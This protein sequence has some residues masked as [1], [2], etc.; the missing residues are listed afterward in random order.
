MLL[1]TKKF[2]TP[3]Q[4]DRDRAR[5]KLIARYTIDQCFDN[6]EQLGLLGHLVRPL[7]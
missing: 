3:M 2:T 6:D 4:K 5:R 7:L 1:V